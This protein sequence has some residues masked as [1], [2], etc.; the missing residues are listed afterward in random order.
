LNLCL[1]RGAARL[2]ELQ[3]EDG[4][5]R[6]EYGGPGFLLPMAVATYR[7]AGQELPA[8]ARDGVEAQLRRV[9]DADG[10]VGLHPEAPGTLFTTS[11]TYAA[12]RL[13]GVPA[14]DPDMARARGWLR[15]RGGPVGAASWGKFILALLNLYPYE[16]LTPVLPELW[17][18]PKAA[19]VHPWRLWCHA[20]QVYLPMAYLYGA[21][22]A[23][24]ADEQVVALREELYVEPYGQIDFAAHRDTVAPCDDL[25]PASPELKLVNRA[26][27]LFERLRP[28]GLRDRALAVLLDH[29]RAEDRATHNI[30]IGPVNA[31]LNTLVHHFA[32]DRLQV[33]RSF[34]ALAEYIEPGHHGVVMKGYNSTALW[35]TAF[36]ARAL[37]AAGSEAGAARGETLELAN[38]FIRDN[39]V[40]QDVPGRERYFR[41]PSVGGWPFSDRLH[42]WPISDCTAEGLLSAVSLADRVG[43]RPVAEEHQRAA[44]R[45]ILHFQNDDGGWPTYERRRAGA[46]L[47]RL[48]PSQ[49][50]GGIMVDHSHIECTGSCV[51]ALALARE[52]YPDLEPRQ[53]K[54]AMA[55]GVKFLRNR[56]QPEGGWPGAWGVCFTYGTWFAVRGL[57]AAG[58]GP[59]DPALARAVAFL[60]EHQRDDGAWAEH[61]DACRTLKWTE[62][63]EPQAVNTAWALLVLVACGRGHTPAAHRAARF[64]MQRQR[65]DGDWPREA[66][67]GVFNH[68]TLIDYDNYRRIFPLWALSEYSAASRG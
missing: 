65:H 58:A 7:I 20:R 67:K 5:W 4:S 45:L 16:G 3:Y 27:G 8:W 66:L 54:R 37:V 1:Q 15:E 14:D 51:E 47:E 13:L 9:I 42:G 62:H 25:Y 29:I 12:S 2:C 17:L 35:D 68:S 52:L 61:P 31:L 28:D 26:Q 34:A 43:G 38:D 23:M 32:G 41:D 18:L 64:L 53:V 39:Q 46:W 48:N 49:V 22:A 33:R 6:S 55:A 36:A 56:Q 63:P 50:F 44:V 60:E 11:L 59:D 21:R 19:P 24:P 10:G 57:L 30:R 40:L